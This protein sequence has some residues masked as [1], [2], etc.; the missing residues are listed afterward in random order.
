MKK[1][2]KIESKNY[3]I[4]TLDENN[5]DLSYIECLNTPAI[6]KFLDVDVNYQHTKDSIM[7][8]I[9][10]RDNVNKFIFGIYTKKDKLIGTHALVYNA[11]TRTGELGVM[12]GDVNYWGKGVPLESRS[13]ILDWFFKYFDAKQMIAG[14]FSQNFPAIYNF[15]RQNWE[16][17]R[18]DKKWKIIDGKEVDFINYSMSKEEWNGK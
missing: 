10:N 17:Y 13:A 18:I 11:E 12:I 6:T 16:M 2:I 3:V 7:K 1:N 15:K 5:I 14:A 9:K 4:R 8:Y